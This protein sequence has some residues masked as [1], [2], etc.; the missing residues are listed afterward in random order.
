MP[1]Q[2][3]GPPAGDSDSDPELTSLKAP[4]CYHAY[5]VRLWRDKPDVPWRVL[6]KEAQTARELHFVDLEQLFLFF[7]QEIDD[8]AEDEAL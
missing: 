6:V 2:S 1:A 7:H 5:L 4:G 8:S 3:G